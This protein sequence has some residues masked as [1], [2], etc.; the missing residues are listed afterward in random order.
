MPP[1]RPANVPSTEALT[2]AQTEPDWLSALQAS[3]SE[4]AERSA[5]TSV[6]S[7][8]SLVSLLSSAVDGAVAAGSL[9]AGTRLPSVRQMATRLGVST[10]TVA[11]AYTALVARQVLASR[12]GAGYFVQSSRVAAQRSPRE[13]AI[14]TQVSDDWLDRKSV[15]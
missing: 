7:E 2:M 10:F 13:L 3:L 1:L 8:P 5:R 12:K 14:S 9:R 15:V 4:R 11:E 6:R